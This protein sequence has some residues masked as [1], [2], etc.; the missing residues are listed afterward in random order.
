MPSARKM[1]SQAGAIATDTKS[2]GSL[3]IS[4]VGYTD[5]A[6]L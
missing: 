5:V 6:K 2:I 1:G 4:L 3:I